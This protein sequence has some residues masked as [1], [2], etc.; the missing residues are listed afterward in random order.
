MVVAAKKERFYINTRIF[1][2]IYCISGIYFFFNNFINTDC[3]CGIFVNQCSDM[4][5]RRQ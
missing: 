4:K 5:D 2:N 3:R 1:F